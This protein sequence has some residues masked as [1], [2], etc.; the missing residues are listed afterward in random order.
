MNVIITETTDRK[1]SN[2]NKRSKIITQQNSKFDDTGGD[3]TEKQHIEVKDVI[4][5]KSQTIFVNI[6]DYEN[7]HP[8]AKESKDV[9]GVVAKVSDDVKTKNSRVVKEIIS[10]KKVKAQVA[11]LRKVEAVINGE[12]EAKRELSNFEQQS[13]WQCCRPFK[14]I[15]SALLHICVG[16]VVIGMLYFQANVAIKM[17]KAFQDSPESFTVDTLK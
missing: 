7:W 13:R 2:F 10:I 9:D 5:D 17:F 8:D 15:C 11:P 16:V 14:S 12:Q 6:A 3:T 1:M 4:V